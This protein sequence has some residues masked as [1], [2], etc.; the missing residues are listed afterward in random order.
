MNHEAMK[1]QANRLLEWAFYHWPKAAA[2]LR[3][4][5]YAQIAG[6]PHSEI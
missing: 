3:A 4:P 5:K 6:V 1:V 2:G